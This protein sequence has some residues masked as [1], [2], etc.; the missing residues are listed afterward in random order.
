MSLEKINIAE[1]E[2]AVSD[3]HPLPSPVLG[4]RG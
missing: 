1:I 2:P 3:L 4:C